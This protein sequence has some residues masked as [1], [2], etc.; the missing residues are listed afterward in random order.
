MAGGMAGW[1]GGVGI[2]ILVLWGG[3]TGW[4]NLGDWGGSGVLA[5]SVEMKLRRKG[6]EETVR[7]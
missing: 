4:R 5:R 1:E 3:G 6:R 7:S 2:K